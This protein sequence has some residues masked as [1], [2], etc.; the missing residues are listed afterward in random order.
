MITIDPARFPWNWRVLPAA[1]RPVLADPTLLLQLSLATAAPQP[2][3]DIASPWVRFITTGRPSARPGRG[4]IAPGRMSRPVMTAK[5]MIEP[6]HAIRGGVVETPGSDQVD[7]AVRQRIAPV[8]KVRQLAD[9]ATSKPVASLDLS[10][11]LQYCTVT[12]TRPWLS[13]PFLN[14]RGW[15]LP[16]FAAGEISTGGGADN[17]GIFPALPVACIVAKDLRIAASWTNDDA[18]IIEQAMALGPFALLGREIDGVS[19]ALTLNGM[20][21]IGWICQVMPLLPPLGAP[22]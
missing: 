8:V 3:P 20:Q 15:F 22:A 21:I 18:S 13:Q 2:Q 12:I 19:G 10:F 17:T 6:P 9:E 7:P 11:S 16:G 4:Q 14:A 5:E 1:R